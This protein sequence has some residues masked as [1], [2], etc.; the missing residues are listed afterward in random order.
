MFGIRSAVN[1]D[2]E[3][4]TVKLFYGTN[5]LLR[6]FVDSSIL[7]SMIFYPLN[8]LVHKRQELGSASLN[9][10]VIFCSLSLTQMTEDK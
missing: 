8:E 5:V 3:Y 9:T 6:K 1:T 10:T 7:V 2:Y 4:A